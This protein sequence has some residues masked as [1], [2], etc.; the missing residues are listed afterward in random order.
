LTLL[1]RLGTVDIRRLIGFLVSIGAGRKDV[2]GLLGRALAV[3]A[4]EVRQDGLVR[5]T[6][7]AL[8]TARIFGPV[9]ALRRAET[10]GGNWRW[11]RLELSRNERRELPAGMELRRCREADIPL[12]AQLEPVASR[13]AERRFAAGGVLWMVISE[14][15]PAFAAWTFAE[16]VP[17]GQAR[18]GWLELPEDSTQLKD[19]VTAEAARGRGIA[20]AAVSLIADH[21]AREGA[22][23]LV[24]RVEDRNLASRRVY[25]KLGFDTLS[26]D[27]PVRVEFA[28]QGA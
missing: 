22:T 12:F 24:G 10:A 21:V 17:I 25:G 23:Y 4:R 14:G 15:R 7:R 8:R 2:V 5:T 11:Y 19:L 9:N 28:R 6:R 16:R 13:D 26:D 20:T 3:T 1:Q 18:N 27:D